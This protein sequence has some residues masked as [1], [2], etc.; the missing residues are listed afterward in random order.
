MSSC[1]DASP[2]TV[3]PGANRRKS[4]SLRKVAAR[5][6]GGLGGG[7]QNRFARMSR[8][9]GFSD[10]D[11]RQM[12]PLRSR[13][14][15][16]NV[17]AINVSRPIGKS[18][19]RMGKMRPYEATAS[20]CHTSRTPTLTEIEEAYAALGGVGEAWSLYLCRLAGPGRGRNL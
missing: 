8:D 16:K 3:W 2:G 14:R 11:G 6:N 15:A 18:N 7:N 12:A 5:P 4:F 1:G 20:Q 13:M 9:D 19:L 17:G 10:E